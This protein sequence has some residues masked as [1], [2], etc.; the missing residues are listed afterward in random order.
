MN[1]TGN[2]PFWDINPV[3]LTL[4]FLCLTIILVCILAYLGP[5]K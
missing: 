4:A 5:K 3:S 2:V 1:D